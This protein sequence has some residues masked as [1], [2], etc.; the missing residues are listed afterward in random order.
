VE[1]GVHLPQIDWGREP[2]SLER[3]TGVARA[4]ERL[5]F[6]T[7][8]ANDHLVY[9]RPWLDGPLALAAVIEAAPSVRLMTTVA[10]PVVRGPVALAKA[11]GTL[12]LLSGGRLDAGL[13][14]GSTSRDYEAVGIP[15]DERWARFDDAVGAMRAL[16]TPDHG[17]FVGRWYDTTGVALSP[18]PAQ[19][20]GP[21]IYIGSWGSA[22]GLRRVARL[23]DGWLASCYNTTPAAFAAARS[24]LDELLAAA[25]R[26]AATFPSAIATGWMHVTD[27]EAEARVTTARV[28]E[29][30]RRPIED[31][32]G[33][34]PIGSPAACV[35]LL[36]RYQEAGLGRLMLWPL[37]DEVAQLE[38][39]AGDVVP[40]LRP[41]S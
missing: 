25:A 14:P 33:R 18:P 10:L 12:D 35:D 41:A 21:P 23:G 11:L 34:L 6:G 19:V 31:V 7:I 40:Q 3:V 37:L 16:W 1:F 8:C 15:Y 28:S 27:D 20:H 36:G 4:A 30:L 24:T 29:M 5:G 39:F 2:P 17:P 13:G 9:Q 26:D 38:R 22:A 32:A